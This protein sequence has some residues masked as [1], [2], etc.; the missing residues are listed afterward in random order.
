MGKDLSEPGISVVVGSLE[1]ARSIEDC[2]A[3]I[4][5][6]ETAATPLEVIVVDASRDKTA[7][8]ARDAFPHAH[9][10]QLPPGTL[11]PVLWAEGIRRASGD[12]VGLT[13]GHC[14]VPSTWVSALSSHL[15]AT[16]AGAGG[17][18]DLAPDASLVD[19]A[20]YFLRYSAF[21]SGDESHAREVPELP[22]DN[23]M[24]SR[25][26][27]ERLNGMFAH[28][29]WEPEFHRVLHEEGKTLMLVP[30]AAASFTRSFPIGVISAHRFAHGRHYGSWRVREGGQSFV[31]VVLASPLVPFV[32]AARIA[33]RV[34]RRPRYRWRF[35]AASPLVLWLAA[36][37]AAGEAAGA[38]EAPRA[39]R[40]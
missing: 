31:R 14:I 16:C 29:F 27:L 28:G 13:T 2:L 26:N 38:M 25:P 6:N 32:L 21:M 12:C 15:T 20:V 30:A 3:S 17:P 11:T 23:A 39:N 37:W 24:Y 33:R 18:L 40:G 4:Y 36:C 5:R 19:A 35:V 34:L 8:I 9:V 1:S 7:R 10:V 22:G